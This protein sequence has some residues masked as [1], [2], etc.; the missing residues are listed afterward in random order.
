MRNVSVSFLT[1]TTTGA[2]TCQD[3]SL[4]N[5]PPQNMADPRQ[6]RMISINSSFHR[7]SG[8][9]VPSHHMGL[10]CWSG[11]NLKLKDRL[12]KSHKQAAVKGSTIFRWIHGSYSPD[13]FS[14][15]HK[16]RILHRCISNRYSSWG[17]FLCIKT[18][19]P[20]HQKKFRQC[21]EHRCRGQLE[22]PAESVPI[23]SHKL[24]QNEQK[25][26]VPIGWSNP[27]PRSWTDLLGS[28]D[29]AVLFFVLPRYLNIFETLSDE[30]TSP[31]H[32][33]HLSPSSP[34]ILLAN[35]KKIGAKRCST[36]SAK[37]QSIEDLKF[38]TCY[39]RV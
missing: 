2:L 13:L 39:K 38:K 34:P 24:T 23:S 22:V 14:T 12:L 8:V 33:H 28:G 30:L 9:Y 32:C 20:P 35:C 5:T 36:A 3:P 16:H 27:N 6:H 17:L 19:P 31:E 25:V 15:F 26:S 11:A 18:W 7:H 1:C 37:T 10:S 21:E 29:S 4:K